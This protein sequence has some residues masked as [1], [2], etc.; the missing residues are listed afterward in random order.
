MCNLVVASC[1]RSHFDEYI[2]DYGMY[3]PNYTADSAYAV[4]ALCSKENAVV[5]ETKKPNRG[6]AQIKAMFPHDQQIISANSRYVDEHNAKG[7]SFT[8][9]NNKFSHL[10]FDQ[11]ESMYLTKKQSSGQS[12][13]AFTVTRSGATIPAAIDW[14]KLGAVTSGIVLC[15]L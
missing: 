7:A 14:R 4:P 5:R 3:I 2:I 11:F 12:N 10:S 15:M 6:M 1:C 13:A 8:M 9:K